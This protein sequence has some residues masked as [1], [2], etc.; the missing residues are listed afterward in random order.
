MFLVVI[1]LIL[2]LGMYVFFNHK[3]KYSYAIALKLLFIFA[4]IVIGIIY[5][6]KTTDY[7]YSIK[8]DAAIYE[9]IKNTRL[10][11]HK[12][13]RIYTLCFAAI[14]LTSVIN[15]C[16]LRRQKLIFKI[17]LCLPVLFF[18][19]WT[20]Y[21]TAWQM[22]IL[23]YTTVNPVILSLAEHGNDVCGVLFFVYM[24]LPYLYF[25]SEFIHTKIFMK[26]ERIALIVFCQAVIDGFIYIMF[27]A[28][29][30]SAIWISNVGVSMVPDSPYE[31]TGT[32]LLVEVYWFLLVAVIL[33][34]WINNPEKSMPNIIRSELVR[35]AGGFRKNLNMLL[36][37]YKNA[38][39]A[40]GQQVNLIRD[41]LTDND[42]AGAKLSA[43]TGI[44]IINENLDSLEKLLSLLRDANTRFSRVDIKECINQALVPTLLP[45]D[46]EIIREY[47]DGEIFINGDYYSLTEVFLN[48]FINAAEA[49]KETDRRPAI[50]IKIIS[51]P[52]YHMITVRDNGKGISKKDIKSIFEMFYSTKSK[53][54]NSGIGLYYVQNTIKR[55]SGKIRAISEE[56][57]FTEFQ[58][59][60]PVYKA[61]KRRGVFSYGKYQSCN[62]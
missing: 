3:N 50:I 9:S 35:T 22:Y 17:M 33:S 8:I 45:A 14:M 30:F 57:K 32:K 44:R 61:K 5:M 12:I 25:F 21:H 18:V 31:V 19:V 46:T 51:E 59:A 10:S 6:S 16:M 7:N 41:C 56:N 58:I 49:V 2:F 4:A 11:L 40:T 42:N 38:F 27:A 24:L 15:I 60:L 43:D 55:H 28:G 54:K 20:D 47:P 36:H 29:E 26:R 48:L 52:D 1:L 53:S 62:L 37:I 23:S 13:S 39:I 34:S